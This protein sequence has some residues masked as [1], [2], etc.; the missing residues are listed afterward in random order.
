MLPDCIGD[1]LALAQQA[2]RIEADVILCCGVHFMCETAKIL[3]LG[4]RVIVTDPGVIH[5][6]KKSPRKTF[7][8]LP[9][10]DGCVC[11]EYPHMQLNIIEKW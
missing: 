9:A 6:M 5:K 3:N 8:P 2:T 4:E 7:I 10:N 11:N 1:N